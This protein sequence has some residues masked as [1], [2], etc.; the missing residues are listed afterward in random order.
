[1]K[2]DMK[3]RD[4]AKKDARPWLPIIVFVFLVLMAVAK[5][6]ETRESMQQDRPFNVEPTTT[7]TAR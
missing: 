5:F 3:P 4:E 6:A 2:A 1:M 7:I